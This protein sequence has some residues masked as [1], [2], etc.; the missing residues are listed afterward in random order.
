VFK[1]DLTLRQESTDGSINRWFVRLD[2]TAS[3]Q[4]R[5]S[6][7]HYRSWVP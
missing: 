6:A 4:A 3:N 2:K 5:H 7:H 1:A